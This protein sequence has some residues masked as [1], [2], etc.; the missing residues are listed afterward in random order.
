MQKYPDDKFAAAGSINSD[1]SG[2]ILV[3]TLGPCRA[4]RPARAPLST[5]LTLPQMPSSTPPSK[6]SVSFEMT[7]AKTRVVRAF[8]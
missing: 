3:R 2:D 1:G 5:H 7:Q 6:T 4:N 8:Q